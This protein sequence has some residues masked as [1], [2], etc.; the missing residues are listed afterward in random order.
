MEKCLII[1]CLFLISCKNDTKILKNS[2]SSIE[3]NYVVEDLMENE[4]NKETSSCSVDDFLLLRKKS[5]QQDFFK[6][7]DSVF[8]IQYPN[9]KDR[10]N[11]INITPKILNTYLNDINE[12]SLRDSVVVFEDVTLANKEYNFKFIPQSFKQWKTSNYKN[13][14]YIRYSAKNCSFGLYINY[15]CLIDFEEKDEENVAEEHLIFYHFRIING[16]IVD[17]GRNEA[18]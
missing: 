9:I 5:I 2:I 15:S 10:E 11:S 4:Q 3:K 6:K 16:K 17:F 8:A 18:G 13:N 14:I 7:L 12:Q 1:V